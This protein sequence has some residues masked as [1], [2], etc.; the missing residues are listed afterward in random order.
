MLF[1]RALDKRN[2]I[3]F[4]KVS[5]TFFLVNYKKGGSTYDIIK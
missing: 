3:F 4:N 1:K 5:S 2:N